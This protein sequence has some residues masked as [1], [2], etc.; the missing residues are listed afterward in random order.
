MP[1]RRRWWLLVGALLLAAAGGLSSAWL[2]S[3]AEA[4]VAVLVAAR[5]IGWGHRVAEADLRTVDVP[6]D[7]AAS[8]LPLSQRAEVIG[9]SAAV[10]VPAGTILTPGHLTREELPADGQVL[11][12]LR[13][14]PGSLPARGLRPGERVTVR[15][16]TA[17]SAPVPRTDTNP[18]EGAGGTGGGDG[19]AGGDE[20]GGRFEARV[21]DVGPPGP[22]GETTVDV[23]VDAEHVEAA[24]AATTGRVVLILLGPGR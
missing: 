17:D 15:P 11:L 19:A 4:R 3:A 7:T 14:E 24:T 21:V 12:G 1:R 13:A 10:S 8:L 18:D 16:L 2:L 23:V 22:Q 9:R 6:P 5:P 20:S